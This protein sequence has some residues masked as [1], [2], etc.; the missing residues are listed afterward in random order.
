MAV[1][2]I[3][4]VMIVVR[5]LSGFAFLSLEGGFD[6]GIRGVFDGFCRTQNLCLPGS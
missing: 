5:V 3:M 6:V 4:A 1:I 2:M